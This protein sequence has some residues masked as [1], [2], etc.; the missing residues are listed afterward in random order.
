MICNYILYISHI[1]GNALESKWRRKCIRDTVQCP[2]FHPSRCHS[3][4]YMNTRTA[5]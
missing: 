3:E 2:P 1:Q 5:R 4:C